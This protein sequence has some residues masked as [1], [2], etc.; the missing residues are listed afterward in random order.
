MDDDAVDF[1]LA[2]WREDGQWLVEPL[3]PRVASSLESLTHALRQLPAEAGALGLVSV[4]EEFFVVMR[5]FGAQTR[6]LLSDVTAARDWELA[7]EVLEQLGIPGPIDGDDIAL[8]GDLKLFD[9]LGVGPQDLDFL[10]ADV[11]LYPDEVLSTI[12]ARV[13]FGIQFEAA[14]ESMAQ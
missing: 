6:L 4:A 3:P 11:D 9:D 10:C 13:G 2:A 12:A 1:A 5:V 8:A 14:L 7:D